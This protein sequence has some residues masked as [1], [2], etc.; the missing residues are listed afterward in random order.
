MVDNSTCGGSLTQE[1]TTL[2]TQRHEPP[3]FRWVWGSFNLL[4]LWKVLLIAAIGLFKI[5]RTK[6]ECGW[7]LIRHWLWKWKQDGEKLP[8]LN[9][10]PPHYDLFMRRTQMKS[11]ERCVEEGRD[12]TG[13]GTVRRMGCVPLCCKE[14]QTSD[15]LLRL[16]LSQHIGA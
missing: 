13:E 1:N 3:I 2:S 9:H 5:L 7:M 8:T 4:S 6:P 12:E 11:P 16:V 15:V 14:P 10:P